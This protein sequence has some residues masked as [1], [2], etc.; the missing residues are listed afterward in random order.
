[1]IKSNCMGQIEEPHT[2]QSD[3]EALIIVLTNELSLSKAEL[4]ENI[5][6]RLGELLGDDLKEA[7][8]VVA[9]KQNI[10]GGTMNIDRA[11]KSVLVILAHVLNNVV[12]TR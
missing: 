10:K 2:Q 6:R 9:A 7:F 12:S 1:M 11:H 5:E 3:G 4:V 8:E